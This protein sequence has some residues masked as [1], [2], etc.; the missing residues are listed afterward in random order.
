MNNQTE[1][2]THMLRLLETGELVTMHETRQREAAQAYFK[3]Q[4]LSEVLELQNNLT[5]SS[6]AALTA[7]G[8]RKF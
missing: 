3:S 2:Q 5:D 8:H 4:L 6:H 1:T 7:V